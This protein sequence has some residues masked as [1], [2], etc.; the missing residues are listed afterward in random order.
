MILLIINMLCFYG[1]RRVFFSIS[2]S[3]DNYHFLVSKL[4]IFN[5]GENAWK[6][7][8]NAK[9]NSPISDRGILVD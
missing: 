5:M 6:K 1:F 7:H 2:S 3:D 4:S 8:S 9:V